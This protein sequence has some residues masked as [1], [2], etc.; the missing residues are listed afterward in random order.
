MNDAKE[1]FNITLSV[2]T[3]SKQELKTAQDKV[4]ALK[5]APKLLEDAKHTLNELTLEYD[6]AVDLQDRSEL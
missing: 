1:N 2:L 4:N 5:N 6:I 3:E